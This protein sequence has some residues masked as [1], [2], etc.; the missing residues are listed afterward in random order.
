LHED[1]ERHSSQRDEILQR[2]RKRG[3]DG[4]LNSELNEICYR[5]GARLW[6]LRKAGWVIVT[7]S[8]GGG[9]YKFILL[10]EPAE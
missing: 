5:Y 4:V 1:D 6:E 9:L 2:L 10:R 8:L 3:R 7:Q